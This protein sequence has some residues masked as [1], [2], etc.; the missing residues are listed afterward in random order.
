LNGDPLEVD[1]GTV[2]GRAQAAGY[3]AVELL[4]NGNPV[5][6]RAL[7]P[8]DRDLLL[9]AVGRTSAQSLYRRFFGVR[10]SFTEPEIGF[11]LNVDFINHVALVASLEEDGRQVVAGG[12]RYVV[13][14]PGTAEVAFAVVDQYQGRGLGAALMRH[15]AAI[16]RKAGLKEFVAE[17][18]PDN[19]AM[20]KVFEKSGLRLASRREAGVV[21]VSLELA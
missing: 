12:G 14:G 17:V 10:R 11:F 1:P 21:H 15:L 3:S 4:A 16:A 13:V 6:I 5:Q 20:L 19:I 2:P 8:E 7:R 18:L 9:A